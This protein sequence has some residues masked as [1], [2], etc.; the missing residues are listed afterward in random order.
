MSAED[1]GGS[2]WLGTYPSSVCGTLLTDEEIRIAAGLRIGA[3]I[4]SPHLCVDCG[5]AVTASGTHGLSCLKSRG[6]FPRHE[7]MKEIVGRALRS[8]GLPTRLEPLGLCRGTNN[9]RP[10]GETLVPW[11]SGQPLAFDVTCIDSFAPSR[12]HCQPGVTGN[13]TPRYFGI[14]EP[15]ILRYNAPPYHISLVYTVSPQE[16]LYPLVSV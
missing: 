12:Q 10:A 6:R 1:V 14:P 4:E 16:I 13:L 15:N 7:N 3:P 9:K 2:E 5:A 8:A 11:Q